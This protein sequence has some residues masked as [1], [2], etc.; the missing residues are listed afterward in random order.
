MGQDEAVR[1]P[2]S[3][4]PK[5]LSPGVFEIVDKLKMGMWQSATATSAMVIV[6]L[7]FIPLQFTSPGDKRDNA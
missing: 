3:R 5:R 7:S 1:K 6:S 2:H 4:P